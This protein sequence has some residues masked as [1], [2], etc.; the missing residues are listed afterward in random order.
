MSFD[1]TGQMS[2]H[3]FNTLTAAQ[4][5]AAAGMSAGQAAAIA[6][7]L[8]VAATPDLAVLATKSDIAS[9]RAEIYRALMFQAG[10]IIA[11]TVALVKLIPGAG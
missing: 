7:Q 2:T 8:G 6:S 11:V 9:L 5:L 4:E 3:T 1:A 10:A